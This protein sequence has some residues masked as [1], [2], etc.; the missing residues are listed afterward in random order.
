MSKFKIGDKAR[1][2]MNPSDSYHW[3]LS[4]KMNAYR[5]KVVTIA[6]YDLE[7]DYYTIE[8]DD[9]CYCWGSKWLEPICNNEPEM[10][11]ISFD[12]SDKDAAHKMVEEAIKSYYAPQDWT[13]E[14]IEKAKDL[15]CEMASIV[16]MGG[17][18][19][20]FG[21]DDDDNSITC[22]VYKDSFSW[23]PGH[24]FCAKPHGRDVFNVWIG[25]CVALCKALKKPIP[26]FIRYK[27]T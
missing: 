13:K 21:Y 26:D 4:G 10:I 18:D 23:E 6:D 12:P 27:N 1:V 7:E 2:V 8:E 9:E 16:L 24:D 19:L 5:G 17:G 15:I 25:K 3:K 20:F 14:E 22:T 11:T